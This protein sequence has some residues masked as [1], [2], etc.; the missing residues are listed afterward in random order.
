MPVEAVQLLHGGG[1]VGALLCAAPGGRGHQLHRQRGD[2]RGAWPARPEPSGSS[3][4]SAATRR[5]IVCEDADIA[6]RRTGLRP[7][8]LHQLRPEL[9]LGAAGLRPAVALRRVRR[10]LHRRGEDAGRRRPARPG[11]RRRLHGGRRRRRAGRALDRGGAG[12]RGHHHDRRQPATARPSPRPW[13]P[14]R[15]ADAAVVTEEV[16]GALVSVLPYDDFDAVLATC[17]E[18]RYGLQAGLF[19][20]D[21][22]PH[23]HRLAR[24][25]GRRA[26]RQRLVELPARPRAVR[27]GEGLRLR[28]RVAPLDD[29]GLHHR[30]DA[31]AARHLA[32]GR[33]MPRTHDHEQDWPPMTDDGAEAHG[34]PA[35]VLRRRV[36]LR[37][38]RPHQHRAA[39]RVEPQQHRVRHRRHEQ[40]AAHAAD[41]YARMSGKPGVLLMHVGPGMMNAVTGVATAALDSVPLVVIAG[42]V[43]SYYYGRHP[44]QEV[45]LH[46]DADQTAIFRPFVKRAWHAHR[47]QDLARLPRAGL[48][49]RDL[50]PAGRGA[51]ER[52]DGPVLPAAARRRRPLPAAG[53]RRPARA[54][55]GRWR[56]ASPPRC[57]GAQRPLIYLGGGLRPRR[58]PCARCDSSSSTSTSRSPTR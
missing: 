52:A 18:S 8:R 40:T 6:A 35:E 13:S 33:R 23:R 58:R 3:W 31:D 28:P 21:I 36:R 22:A 29:R 53:R 44:H 56:N 2:R 42:D 51:A 32:V 46:A 54:A 1:E 11:H 49:D 10:R 17:N 37:A 14:T 39:G 45:N 7:H 5:R 38:V 12:R 20:H 15:R 30:E 27:R 16:F 41:G 48:L 9:H 34:G 25:G 4:S 57:S 47:V 24:A 50:R 55:G 43:P 26:G 19:T